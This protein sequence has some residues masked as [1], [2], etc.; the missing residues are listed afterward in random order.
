[1]SG[2]KGRGEDADE[3][4]GRLAG[5][6]S[7][8]GEDG[9]VRLT[10]DGE[11][12]DRFVLYATDAGVKVQLK[13]EGDEL[14]MTQPQMADLFGVTRQNVNL[15]L[16]NI[17]DE[18]ELD[19]AATSKDSLQVR[20]EGARRV[21]RAV[22]LYTLDAIIAVGYRIS[23]R[24][25]TLFRKWATDKL[26]RF[27]TKGFVVDAARLA[28]PG[29]A[30]H[31]RELREIIRDIRASEANVYREVTRICSLCSDY[32]DLAERERTRFFA[33]VQNKLHY[34]VTGMTGA[35]IRKDRAD[36]G[37]PAMGLTA[38]SGTRPTQKDVMTAKNFLGEAEIRD[39]NRTTGML[40]DYVEQE[41]DLG[42]LVTM[43]DAQA[44]IDTFIRNNERPLLDGTGSV[45]RAD[46][47]AHAKAQ[48]RIYKEAQRRIAQDKG[49]RGD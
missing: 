3:A 18:G 4:L 1:M 36:A 10:E 41:L 25:G 43:A 20:Q 30:D 47:D 34:A 16:K 21:R 13:Y 23:S 6:G 5:P 22:T 26:V 28:D 31:F 15:H 24:Q 45:S 40:L 42:R 19:R 7:P 32:H 48:Y 38:W 14:W 12:G 33:S 8:R 17:Y 46:A 44:K 49:M 2:R 35:E 39:L 9:P 37:A 29:A 11:T 27:A